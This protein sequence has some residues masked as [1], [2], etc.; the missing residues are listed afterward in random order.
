MKNPSTENIAYL[1]GRRKD[2]GAKPHTGIDTWGPA[3]ARHLLRRTGF[4][5]TVQEVETVAALPRDQVVELLLTEEFPD[6]PFAWI[7]E[8]YN[9]RGWTREQRQQWQATNRERLRELRDWWFRRLLRGPY[10]LQEKMLVFWHGHFVIEQSNVKVAQ[11]MYNYQA[12]LRRNAL[13]NFGTFVKEMYKE[14]AM[15]IYLNGRENTAGNP[16]ENFAREL[17]ELFTMGI[18]NYTEADIKEAARALTGWR[19]RREDNSSY[20]DLRR[21]D[22]DQKTFLGKSG[23]FTGDHIID[24]ILEQDATALFICRKIYSW[25]VNPEPDEARVSELATLF[26]S[27]G[28]EIKP[29]LRSILNSDYFYETNNVGAIIKPPIQLVLDTAR[30]FDATDQDFNYLS[31]ASAVLGQELFSPPNVAGWPGQRGWI[32]PLLLATRSAFGELAIKGGRIDRKNYRGTGLS[33]DTMQFARS[34]GTDSARE[35]ID[36]WEQHLLTIGIDDVTRENLLN[37]LLEGAEE[38]DWSLNYPGVEDRVKNSLAQ[39]LRLP[40]FQLM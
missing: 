32:S 36:L 39:F 14:P 12:M 13:G 25:L 38:G 21:Y 4:S 6:K 7:D 8:P 11:Y 37:L 24:I 40:E 34:F 30:L 9:P 26:R 1:R 27:S 33:I 2:S 23:Y 29:V 28:Y 19:I 16:N 17:L 18:G 10:N 31:R 22:A 15:L 5:A 35:L 3:Q 20:L